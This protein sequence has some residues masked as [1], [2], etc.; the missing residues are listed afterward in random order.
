MKTFKIFKNWQTDLQMLGFVI[1]GEPCRKGYIIDYPIKGVDDMKVS[2]KIDKKVV[3]KAIKDD[4]IHA[5]EKDIKKRNKNGL[6]WLKTLIE[7]GDF[8][9]ED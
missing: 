4:L 5:C 6:K 3:E 7:Q 2:M 9:N 8:D 1:I